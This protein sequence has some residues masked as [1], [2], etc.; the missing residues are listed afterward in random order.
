MPWI[1]QCSLILDEEHMPY[2]STGLEFIVL[3]R[4]F[5]FRG[6]TQ[7]VAKGWGT[8]IDNQTNKWVD[9]PCQEVFWDG[10]IDSPCECGLYIV[11]SFCNLV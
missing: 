7:Q 8:V 6:N 2:S 9:I 4:A 1:N 10:G 11:H 5:H 3:P